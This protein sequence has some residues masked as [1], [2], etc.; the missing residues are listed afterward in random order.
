MSVYNYW[1]SFFVGKM[2][3]V[4]MIYH[5]PAQFLRGVMITPGVAWKNE[6]YCYPVLLS[7][8]WGIL[9]YHSGPNFA[10]LLRRSAPRT[11]TLRVQ[12]GAGRPLLRIMDYAP[13]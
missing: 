1:S 9:T 8:E 6:I 5:H 13:R 12:Y 2:Y 11:R 3:G 4:I 7:A 10:L